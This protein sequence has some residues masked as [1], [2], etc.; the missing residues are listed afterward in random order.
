MAPPTI[1]SIFHAAQLSLSKHRACSEALYALRA[2]AT[3]RAAFDDDVFACIAC[4]LRHSKREK[5]AEKVVGNVLEFIVQFATKHGGEAA[6]DEDFVERVSLRLLKLSASKDKAVRFRSVQL[7]GQM[8]ERIG[9]EV[10]L[11]DELFEEVEAKMLERCRDREQIV[12]AAATKAVARLQD[13]SQGKQD[14]VTAELLRMLNGKP[15]T[16]MRRRPS[17]AFFKSPMNS[18]AARRKKHRIGHRCLIIFI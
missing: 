16:S 4:V 18:Q 17:K 2:A 11:S 10:E 3:D 6:F 13:P 7:I 15:H 9:D 5:A 8:L 1:A 14:K 12:R